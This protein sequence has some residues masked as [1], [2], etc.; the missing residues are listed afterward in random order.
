[1]FGLAG[2]H[3]NEIKVCVSVYVARRFYF[4]G[5]GGGVVA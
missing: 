2:C 1:M 5:G 3:S 4:G